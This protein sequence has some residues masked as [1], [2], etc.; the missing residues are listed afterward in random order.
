MVPDRTAAPL[1]FAT[2]PLRGSVLVEAS[3]GTGKT[4]TIAALVLR[5][6]LE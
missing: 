3:A 1:D 2:A 5:L 4:W 6:L